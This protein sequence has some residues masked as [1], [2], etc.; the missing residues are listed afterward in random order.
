MVTDEEMEESIRLRQSILDEI[1]INYVEHLNIV[2]TATAQLSVQ[3]F[4]DLMECFYQQLEESNKRIPTDFQE[5]ADPEIFSQ[6]YGDAVT[7]LC[8]DILRPDRSFD[9]VEKSN[10]EGF[11]ILEKRSIVASL[12]LKRGRMF[13]IK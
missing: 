8:F 7:Y 2:R 4:Y 3:K 1:Q 10:D 9:S 6:V 13:R 5:F 12:I 11:L